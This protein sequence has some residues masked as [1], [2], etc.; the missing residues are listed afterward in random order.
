MLFFLIFRIGGIGAVFNRGN[1]FR[2]LA[3]RRLS[4]VVKA[5]E[6]VP[7]RSSYARH[8]CRMLPEIPRK[9]DPV[10]AC[11][12]MAKL[13]NHAPCT[14]FRVVVDHNDLRPVLRKRLHGPLDLFHDERQRL[15][16][17]IAGNDKADK[18]WRF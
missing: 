8:E 10:P 7:L 5:D 18:L 15:S 11:F 16:R 4:V 1:Q 14:V 9:T 17:V 12:L 13:L 3:R 2:C 6:D